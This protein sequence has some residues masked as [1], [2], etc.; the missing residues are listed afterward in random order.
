MLPLVPGILLAA[1]LAAA[2]IYQYQKRRSFGAAFRLSELAGMLQSCGGGLIVPTLAFLGFV[3]VGYPLMPIVL[4]VGM[5]AVFT[6][7]A[8]VFRATEESRKA[9]ARSS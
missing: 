1:P 7:Y 4:F 2:G 5:A 9:G 3:A 8:M 6:F